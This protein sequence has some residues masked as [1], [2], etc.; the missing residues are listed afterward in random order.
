MKATYAT[1]RNDE[2]TR[3]DTCPRCGKVRR[4]TRDTNEGVILDHGTITSTIGDTEIIRVPYQPG[5]LIVCDRCEDEIITLG[6]HLTVQAL[7]GMEHT[8]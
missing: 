3:L 4:C 6:R 2:I 1:I 7:E 8:I 5:R